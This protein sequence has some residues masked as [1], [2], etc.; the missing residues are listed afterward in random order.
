MQAFLF[1]RQPEATWGS[2]AAAVVRNSPDRFT[3]PRLCRALMRMQ[4]RWRRVRA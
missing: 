3:Q 2:A 1:V 4:K